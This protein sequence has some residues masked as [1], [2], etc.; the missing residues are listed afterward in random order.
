[1]QSHA[2]YSVTYVKT[3]ER[4]FKALVFLVW[5]LVP[6]GLY[7]A[8][9]D[10]PPVQQEKEALAKVPVEERIAI[11]MK[12][13]QDSQIRMFIKKSNPSLPWGKVEK[14]AR[15]EQKY[16]EKYDVPLHIG[17]AITWKESG[18]QP[19]AIS[20]TGCCLGL[21]QINFRAHKEEY[22]IPSRQAL[23]TLEKNIEI[24]YKMI[25]AYHKKYG[26]YDRAIQRYYGSSRKEDNKMYSQQ[27]MN[28]AKRIKQVTT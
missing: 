16:A 28:K 19:K 2:V 11:L 14:I 9:R 20:Y 25:S 17:L 26:S 15:L 27:V 23:F 24:S 18:F 1:M 4:S 8:A 12:A 21:K 5:V 13:K 6:V 22:N 10:T 3:L 7:L